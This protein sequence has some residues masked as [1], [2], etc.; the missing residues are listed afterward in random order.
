MSFLIWFLNER[1]GSTT[2]GVRCLSRLNG[3]RKNPKQ[4]NKLLCAIQ[5]M[6]QVS[7]RMG[8]SPPIYGQSIK[9][10]S[11]TIGCPREVTPLQIM[12]QR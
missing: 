12:P 9:G 7:N 3:L 11:H 2:F 1:A 8:S 6:F 10:N 4:D 5:R